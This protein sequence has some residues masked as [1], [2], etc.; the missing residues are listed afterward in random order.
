MES[1][2]SRIVFRNASQRIFYLKARPGEEKDFL[3][4]PGMTLQ[5]MDE[6]EE[7]QLST[8]HPD[9]IDVAKEA[10]ALGTTISNLQKQLDDEKAKN[11][12][13]LAK[14]S[15]MTDKMNELNA[16]VAKGKR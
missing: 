5:A 9:I 11:K 7:K 15:E 12:E 13:L 6:Q 8:Y 2:K 4:G 14:H 16:K 10:P 3:F 1:T